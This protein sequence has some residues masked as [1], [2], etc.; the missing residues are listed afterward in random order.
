MANGFA[1]RGVVGGG[2]G[3]ADRR[4]ERERTPVR[5]MTVPMATKVICRGVRREVCW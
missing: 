3:S 4:Q 2:P 5:R 1:V